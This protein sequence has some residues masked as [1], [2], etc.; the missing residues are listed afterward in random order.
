M[1]DSVGMY[2]LEN[3]RGMRTITELLLINILYMF[4][5]NLKIHVKYSI[6]LCYNSFRPYSLSNR[7]SFQS[8]QTLE[9]KFIPIYK[10]HTFR[11]KIRDFEGDRK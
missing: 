2:I 5:L 6:N 4:A 8:F 1:M 11:P 10:F 9:E 3:R 7:T